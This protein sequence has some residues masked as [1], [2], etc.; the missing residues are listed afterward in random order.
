MEMHVRVAAD[1][2][3]TSKQVET[4]A[5]AV[6]LFYDKFATPL[7]TQYDHNP[8]RY[9]KYWYEQNDYIYTKHM[10]IVLNIW[11]QYS[12]KKTVPGKKAWMSMEEFRKLIIDVECEKELT[13]RE[14]SGTFC[15]SMMSQV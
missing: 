8:W 3:I 10:K 11:E 12:G 6:K 5:E 7:F 14:M 9:D 2:F 15:F 13:E 4:Y 1:I